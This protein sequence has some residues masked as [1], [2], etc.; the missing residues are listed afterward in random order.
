MIAKKNIIGICGSASQNSANLSILKWIAASEKS[1]FQLDIID[2][3][4]ELPHFQT[5]L[6]LKNVPD[7][8]VEFRERIAH[9]D[10][11]IICTPEYVYSI[12]SGLKNAIEWC[13]STNV[14]TD[15]ACGLITASASGLKGQVE[16]KLVMETI[17]AKFT[18]DTNLLI[19]SV[20]GKVNKV[21]EI[22]DNETEN[23]LNKFI[24]S[25]NNWIGN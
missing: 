17:Q 23:E 6:T 10:G 19:Q 12:P 8:I 7:K 25:F 11:V 22:Q 18:N 3:L 1:N 13:V 2:K 9:A 16:L 4:S 15:K 20:K 21:G 14:F 24:L 5:E